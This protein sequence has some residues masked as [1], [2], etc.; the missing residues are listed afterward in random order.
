MQLDFENM[1]DEMYDFLDNFN[2]YQARELLE[3]FDYYG[4]DEA[5]SCGPDAVDAFQKC[6]SMLH[7]ESCWEFVETVKRGSK[8]TFWRLIDTTTRQEVEYPA[9]RKQIW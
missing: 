9:E 8:Y 6:W 1:T 5:D 4:I 3:W 7:P 2:I